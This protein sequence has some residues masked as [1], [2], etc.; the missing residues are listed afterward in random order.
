MPFFTRRTT[1]ATGT[2]PTSLFKQPS[3]R[4][5]PRMELPL[6]LPGSLD[7]AFL[8]QAYT[9]LQMLAITWVSRTDVLEV[10][11]ERLET[12]GSNVLASTLFTAFFSTDFGET[13]GSSTPG[14]CPPFGC[15]VATYTLQGNSIFAGNT[16]GMFLSTD[17]GASW[18][19]INEGFP[20]CPLPAV[21]AS[22]ADDNYL[23]AGTFGEGVWRKPAGTGTPTPTP[24]PPPTATPTPI[25]TPTPT[26][27]VTPSAT[28]SP[29]ATPRVTPRPR[30]TPA[31]RPTPPR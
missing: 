12:K 31:P 9:R 26:S 21:E 27:T 1:E 2:R 19:D 23:F 10:D 8:L 24:T 20:T 13:W 5:S 14:N 30:P 18:T 29:T 16:A 4:R 15:G 7:K 3:S 22:C 28:P 17:S 25:A 6:L 11:I